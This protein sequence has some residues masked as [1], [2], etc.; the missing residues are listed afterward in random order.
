[1]GHIDICAEISMLA[2]FLAAPR[3]G[4][5]SAAFH[6]FA[7]LNGHDCSQLVMDPSYVHHGEEPSGDWAA[8]YPKEKRYLWMH[9]HHLAKVFKSPALS[10]Q[11]MQK[12]W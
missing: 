8:F 1:M 11:I 4:H 9:C 7:Y 3:E 10:M 12:N 5:L 6:V 2:S